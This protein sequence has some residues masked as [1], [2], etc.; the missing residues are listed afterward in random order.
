MMRRRDERGAVAP[1]VA[2]M[3]I[4]LVGIASFA[5]DIG[6]Q[7]V[8]ARDMQAIADIVAMDM[9][10]KLDGRKTGSLLGTTWDTA[11]DDSLE[12][13]D[14]D[15]VGEPLNP[16]PCP[17]NENAVH[18]S[19]ICAAPGI[20]E[21]GV[22]SKSGSA[23][24]THVM[25]QTRTRVDYFFPIFADRGWV[26]KTAYAEAP[27]GACF[28]VGSYAARVR[29]GESPL[30]GPLLGAIGSNLE[31]S[32]LDYQALASAK[33]QLLDLLAVETSAGTV[34]EI[35]SGGKLI[36]LGDFLAAT[37]TALSRKSEHAAEVTLLQSL[38]AKVPDEDVQLSEILDIGTGGASGLDAGLN[39][40]DLVTAAAFAANGENA[41][42]IPELK[43]RLGPLLS[44]QVKAYVTQPPRIAC[45]RANEALSMS[46]QVGVELDASALK[47]DLGLLTTKA[48]L[49]GSVQVASAKGL[50]K[51]VSCDPNKQVVVNVSDGLL[52]V[53]LRLD[54]E[55]SALFGVL[56]VVK[57]PIRISGTTSS[58]GDATKVIVS[59]SDYD[60]PA[61][62]G[63]GNSGLPSLHVDMSGLRPLGKVTDELPGELL[64]TLVN[65]IVQSLDDV[66][67][68]PLLTTLGV[69]LSGADVY[70]MREPAC[71]IPALRG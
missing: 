43:V 64:E 68:S 56:E 12:R 19:W 47:L 46:S 58:S 71:G 6:Y 16:I 3:I 10:R 25:V 57:G 14:D 62:V 31:L 67:L 70:V 5:V 28:S 36:S 13:N 21:N 1:L 22:F 18:G 63:S 30:L 51:S 38:V 60:T 11:L 4:L 44:S 40:L 7:R 50:L 15:A 33:V 27:A 17:A 53:D 29:T 32:V 20:Y 23:P 35:L 52:E 41:L 69:Q 65:P 55:I 26:T 9:A 54:I 45:G 34:E 49:S 24:A 39:V 66:V 8:A 42:S 2:V 37:A 48:D 61:H 59:D